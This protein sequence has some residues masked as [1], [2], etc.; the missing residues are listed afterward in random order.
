MRHVAQI[1]IPNLRQPKH[2]TGKINSERDPCERMAKVCAFAVS[3][4]KRFCLHGE[5][6]KY[7]WVQLSVVEKKSD[8][9][10]L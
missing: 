7:L 4:K 3:F 2:L 6:F 10:Q 9:Q 8:R 5:R 1:S